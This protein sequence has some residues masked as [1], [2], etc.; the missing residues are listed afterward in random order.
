MLQSISAPLYSLWCQYDA[1]EPVG[2]ER[3]DLSSAIIAANVANLHRGVSLMMGAK[4]YEVGDAYKPLDFM[5]YTRQRI[6]KSE[7]VETADRHPLTDEDELR[8][9][10]GMFV[11]DTDDGPNE[12]E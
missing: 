8:D 12:G 5:P 2:G 7:G 10:M 9:I 11:T 1:V 4:E 3:T 6:S